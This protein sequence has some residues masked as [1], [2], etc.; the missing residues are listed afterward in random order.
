[1]HYGKTGG[2]VAGEELHGRHSKVSGAFSLVCVVVQPK[3]I[4]GESPRESLALRL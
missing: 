2:C 4:K 3:N 1:M